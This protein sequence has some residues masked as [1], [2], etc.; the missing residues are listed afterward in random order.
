MALE[1]R[2]TRGLSGAALACALAGAFSLVPGAVLAQSA[3]VVSR[4]VVQA[5]PGADTQTLNAALARLGRDPRDVGA[6]I[7]AGDAARRLG[8]FEAALGFYRRGDA[9]SPGNPRIKAGQASALMLSGDPVA[10]IPVF[11]EAERAGVRPQA[12]AS[13]RG[14]AYDLVGD[15]VTAQQYYRM[16]LP[17]AGDDDLRMRLAISQA[18]AGDADAAEQTLMPLLRRQDKPGWRTRAFTLAIGGETKQAVELAD[19]ILPAKLAQNVAPYL[20][21]MPRLTKAQQAAA[22]NLGRFPRASEI[23]RDEPR[24]AAYRPTRIASADAALVPRG[25]QLGSGRSEAGKKSGNDHRAKAAKALAEQARREAEAAQDRRK[26]ALASVDADRVVPP[27]PRPAIEQNSVELPP[28]SASRA[29]PPAAIATPTPTPALIGTP[30]PN[31][32]MT[33]QAQAK[34]AVTLPQ[35]PGPG[36]DLARAGTA[37]TPA[38]PSEAPPEPGPKQLSLAEIFA[39]I[40]QPTTQAEAASGAVDIRK[41]LPAKPKPPEAIKLVEKP[42]VEVKSPAKPKKPPP[43]THPSRIWVQ[44]GVGRDKEAIVFDWRRYARQAP[45]LFKSRTAYTSE[46]GRTNRILVGPFETLK[47]ANQFVTDLRK[48]GFQGALPWTSP[49]GQIV[50]ALAA[51]P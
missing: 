20:R 41:I 48:A 51:K 42:K 3:P 23:G 24:I 15:N 25:E 18:I 27:E 49:A 28:V 43:P 38:P 30:A 31:P 34:P 50:D 6:L 29:A 35:T 12:I 1:Q 13:D 19:R 4:P 40:G 9:I 5:T 21:Y 33:T 11:A 26:A 16:A 14:L 36:F 10:A 2:I 46:M 39:D 17:G 22:A 47:A 37:T 32:A 45:E 44:I 8:D 7:D